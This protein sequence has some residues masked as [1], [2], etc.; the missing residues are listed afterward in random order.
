M[1]QAP[2]QRPSARLTLKPPKPKEFVRAASTLTSV[3]GV[4]T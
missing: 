4:G 2:L 1:D 3:P